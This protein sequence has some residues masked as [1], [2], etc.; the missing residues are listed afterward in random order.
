MKILAVIPARAGSKGIPN[1]NIRFVAGKPLVSYAIENAL[2]SR[3]VSDVVVTTDSDMVRVIADQMGA[4]VIAR[5]ADLCGDEVTLDAVVFDA[6]NRFNCDVVIT[7]QPTSPTLSV[8]TLDLAIEHFLKENLDTLISAVNRPHLAWMMGADGCVR[9][10]YRKR[11][12]RQFLPPYYV[13]TGAFVIARRAV[14]TPNTR[15]GEKVGVYEVPES[16]SVDIDSYSDL[17]T[18]TIT[19]ESQRV[20]F[21]VNGNNK[22][23]LGHVYRALELADEFCCK[24]DIYYDSNQTERAIFG[25][26]THNLIPVNGIGELLNVLGRE[27]Y[28]LFI[29]DILDTS[30]DYMIAVRTAL[31][32]SKIINFED[33]G[34]GGSRADIVFNALFSDDD[35]PN[36]RAGEKYYIASK[37]FMFY[38]P[39]PIRDKV[40]DVF[41]SFGGADPQNYSDRILAIIAKRKYKDV[42]FHV[43]LGRAKTNVKELVEAGSALANVEV[44][45]DIVD[46]PGIMS[47]CDVG[48]T[49][50]GRTGYELAM[51]GIP[52][53]AMAQNQRE[54]RHGFVCAEN[55]FAYLGLNPTDMLIENTLDA[56]IS[57]SAEERGRLRTAMLS[58]DLRNGRERVMKLINTL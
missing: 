35:T 20:A 32:H 23:G 6:A 10:A 48:I 7:M 3:Y 49:S 45:H 55:G 46:V 50:R 27:R 13:E 51:L 40:H 11:L 30:L 41:I 21:Y 47:K 28:A 53:I 26:T 36:V 9:P 33:A 34:E 8:K 25:E 57:M 56:Y 18:A 16:E 12:N 42:F 39:K 43:V 5:R 52:S 38:R 24:P 31:P 1:K 58:H 44:L 29:N 14:V 17:A 37:L 19:L 22:R 15:I 54:E 2:A 4:K